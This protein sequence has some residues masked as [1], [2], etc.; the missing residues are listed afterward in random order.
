MCT[1]QR[2]TEKWDKHLCVIG[3]MTLLFTML[4]QPNYP[5]SESRLLTA[6]SL[7]RGLHVD[8]WLDD[9]MSLRTLTSLYAHK[10]LWTWVISVKVCQSYYS[11]SYS[12]PET[13]YKHIVVSKLSFLSNVTVIF[14]MSVKGLASLTLT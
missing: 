6:L 11:L 8:L 7:V 14:I 10:R 5:V 3:H 4:R 12:L 13:I 9:T 2:T 1:K